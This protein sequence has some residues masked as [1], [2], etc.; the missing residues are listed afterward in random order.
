[1]SKSDIK[2]K[3]KYDEEGRVIVAEN[4]PIILTATIEEEE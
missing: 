1:M 2:E 3:K 4:V